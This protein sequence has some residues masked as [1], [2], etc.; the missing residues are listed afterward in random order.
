MIDDGLLSLEFE[1]PLRGKRVFVTGHTGFT[2]G[3]LVTWLKHLGCDVSGL[4]LAP[5]TEPNSV[6]GCTNRRRYDLHRWRHP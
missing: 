3:W 5:M 2:G 6:Y 1:A 4:A